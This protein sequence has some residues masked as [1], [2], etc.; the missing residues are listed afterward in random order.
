M[1][2][3][4]LKLKAAMW[5]HTIIDV[6]VMTGWRAVYDKLENHIENEELD[7]WCGVILKDLFPDK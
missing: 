3:N 1:Y 5:E 4:I 6:K 7:F 2:E